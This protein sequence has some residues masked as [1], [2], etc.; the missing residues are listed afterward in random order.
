[1]IIRKITGLEGG[2]SVIPNSTLNDNLSWGA[3]GLL[4]YL[5]SKPDDWQVSITQLINH[6]KNCKRPSGRDQTYA[7]LQELIDAGYVHKLSQRTDNGRFSGV[8]Y[9]VS[10]TPLR[11]LDL[12]LEPHTDYPDTDLPDT[13]NRKQQSKDSNKVKNKQ[14]PDLDLLDD[15]EN[16]EKPKPKKRVRMVYPDDFE[17]FIAEYPDTKGSKKDALKAWKSLNSQEKIQV[18]ASVSHYKD[19]LARETWQKPMYPA[20]YIRGENYVNFA[21]AAEVVEGNKASNIVF[22][23]GKRFAE[24]TVIS[25]CKMWFEGEDWRFENTL[26]PDPAHPE[27]RI[28]TNL[29][30]KARAAVNDTA[31]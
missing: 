8:G 22:I 3:K 27:C 2:Y 17:A 6:T 28:P 18:K 4:A 11:Q 7:I 9:V 26:G 29:V 19:Y 24:E 20:K 15:L 10:P 13:A 30:A 16:Q 1:M 23:N 12:D 25:I 5:C 21:S 14:I 31:A